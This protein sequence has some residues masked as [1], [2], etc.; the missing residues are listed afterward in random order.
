MQIQTLVHYKVEQRMG[1]VHGEELPYI[2][3]APLVDGFSHFPKN[4]TR[5]E[6]AL[7]ES[8][9]IYVANFARTG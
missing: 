7:S 8:F 2:F 5:A 6:L 9:I 4:Y 3:G 1:T